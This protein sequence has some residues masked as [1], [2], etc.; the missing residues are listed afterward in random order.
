LDEDAVTLRLPGETKREEGL[1]P[2]AL[3]D[4]TTT[5]VT[6]E[7]LPWL[8]LARFGVIP[9]RKHRAACAE[10]QRPSDKRRD[11]RLRRGEMTRKRRPSGS[12]KPASTQLLHQSEPHRCRAEW[13]VG[14]PFAP[15]WLRQALS[16]DRQRFARRNFAAES[17]TLSQA[18]PLG[19]VNG[20]PAH[21]AIV[22][23]GMTTLDRADDLDDA[24]GKTGMAA[25]AAEASAHPRQKWRHHCRSRCDPEPNSKLS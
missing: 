24:I 7:T 23:E 17:F 3:A 13:R 14:R 11:L 5:G 10:R 2:D 20:N 12:T 22:I 19:S 18:Y 21:R 8:K 1:S 15:S 4:R 25:T 6:K 9:N 16:D